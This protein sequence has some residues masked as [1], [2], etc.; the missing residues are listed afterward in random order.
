MD[1][2]ADVAVGASGPPGLVIALSELIVRMP[3]SPEEV[4]TRE[5]AILRAV[6]K[7]R[8]EDVDGESLVRFGFA[9]SFTGQV[10]VGLLVGSLVNR[11]A[12]GNVD[13]FHFD[14]WANLFQVPQDDIGEWLDDAPTVE[15][16][17]AIRAHLDRAVP[18]IT[19][20][21][22]Q[23]TL[24]DLAR[25]TCP[26]VEQLEIAR[27]QPAVPEE[28]TQQYVWTVDRCIRS[29][30]QQWTTSSLNLEFMLRQHGSPP[31]LIDGDRPDA[32]S[33]EALNAEI[34]RRAVESWGQNSSTD[35]ATALFGRIQD[36][37]QSLLRQERHEEAST[38]FDF[39]ANLHPTSA[40][41]RNNAAF[42]RIPVDPERAHFDLV[43]AERNGFNPLGVLVHNL[44]I[45]L[46]LLNRDGEALDRVEYYW[47]RE[48]ESLPVPAI[49]W[50]YPDETWRIYW[51]R[52][53]RIAICKVA[54]S[55]A[56]TL[57]RTDR[58]TTWAARQAD[59]DGSSLTVA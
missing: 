30:P 11:S 6:E 36:H 54:I 23:A 31:P 48:R 18:Q 10:V 7:L 22:H 29:D 15:Q 3:T 5:E 45:C 57:G 35:G 56:T 59:L 2:L 44:A 43:H 28:V 38:L 16:A 51:E 32:P 40:A 53:A 50:R 26:S 21:V 9:S 33:P 37:A 39:Y 1:E 46:S 4:Q 19:Q 58:A 42:C 25:L 27:A 24:Q 55:I 8:Q 13:H 20:W 17:E 14:E 52:D 47:Q 12:S 49:L 41:A 34:A